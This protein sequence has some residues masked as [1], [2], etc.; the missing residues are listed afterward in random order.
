MQHLVG[1]FQ[2][3][4]QAAAAADIA[5]ISDDTLF[6]QGDIIRVPEEMSNVMAVACITAAVTFTSAQLQSPSLRQLANMDILPVVRAAVFGSSP[7]LMDLSKNPFALIP[8]ESLTFN[9]NTDDAA[10]IEI[11]GLLWLTDGPAVPVSG[12]I[13]TVRATAAIVLAGG[14]WI[15]GNLTFSQDLPFGDYDVVGMRA[16]SANLLCARLVFPGKPWRPGVPGAN[17]PGDI[18]HPLFRM[19]AGGI[20]GSFNTNNPPTVDMI[21]ISDSA[22]NVLLDLIK[23]G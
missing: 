17:V 14:A 22:E 3:V 21:G 11:Y 19:G 9:T 6:A 13:F 8:N 18:D 1:W 2:D 10:V 16:E 23:R 5:A 4:D 12:E 7:A 15:N 20:M